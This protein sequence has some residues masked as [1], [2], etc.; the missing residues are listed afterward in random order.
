MWAGCL[1][2]ATARFPGFAIVGY[3]QGDHLDLARRAGFRSIGALRVWING[4]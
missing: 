3:E 2:E 1:A 4:R